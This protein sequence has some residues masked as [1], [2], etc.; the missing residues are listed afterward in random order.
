MNEFI[1]FA[2]KWLIL[3]SVPF[4]IGNPISVFVFKGSPGEAANG[5]FLEPS[6]SLAV[7][8][9]YFFFLIRRRKQILP[10]VIKSG[11]LISLVVFFTVASTFWSDFPDITLRRSINFVGATFYGIYFAA[12]YDLKQQVKLLA[13]GFGLVVL[14][15]YVVSTTLGKYGIMRDGVY[16]G[17][18]Q[19][20]YLHKNNLAMQMSL[21][22]II[23]LISLM[24]RRR[25]K[26]AVLAAGLVFSLL[27]V[28]LSRA[29]TGLVLL[30]TLTA[31]LPLSSILRFRWDLRMPV[32]MIGL[33]VLGGANVLI[34]RYQEYLFGAVGKDATLTGRT[35]LWPYVWEMVEKRPWLGYGYEGFWRGLS[36]EECTY[37]WRAV[38]WLPPH[39]H[40]GL[41]ELLLAFGGLGTAIFLLGFF[42]NFLKSLTLIHLDKSPEACWP[43]IYMIFM[44]LTNISE[45]NILSAN[46][47]WSLY[48]AVSLLP[49]NRYSRNMI[50]N[51][52]KVAILP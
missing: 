49:V 13:W 19:G 47:I 1:N 42:M 14:M 33:V 31:I 50:N 4:F 38:G 22:A 34:S 44:L 18:W 3:F 12:R 35:D 11:K 45:K 23:F 21:S 46:M 29:A 36:S 7:Y 6:I 9:I 15:S 39:A 32:L 27:L 43:M 2:E 51:Q 52:N 24:G 16:D 30:I 8:A 10:K 40:N 17:A 26:R 25:K 20:V 48:V 37:V 5:S 28:F 41:L